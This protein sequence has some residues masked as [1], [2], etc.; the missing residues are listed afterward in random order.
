[1]ADTSRHSVGGNLICSPVHHMYFSSEGG[2]L[3]SNWMRVDGRTLPL[4]RHCIGL[5][6]ASPVTV[7]PLLQK[8]KHQF[9]FLLCTIKFVKSVTSH[10]LD[11]SVTNCHT[12]SSVTYFMDDRTVILQAW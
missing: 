2:S 9:Q 5:L 7:L 10:A 4:D 8:V 11:P 1:M 12:F 3:E 6:V